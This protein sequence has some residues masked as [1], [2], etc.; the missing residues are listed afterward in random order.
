MLPGSDAVRNV[1]RGAVP[2]A[3]PADNH[4]FAAAPRK[5][6]DTADDDLARLARNKKQFKQFINKGG[7]ISICFDGHASSIFQRMSN[8]AMLAKE[9]SLTTAHSTISLAKISLHNGRFSCFSPKTP[10]AVFFR[11]AEIPDHPMVIAEH[12]LLA[13]NHL[14]NQSR[15]RIGGISCILLKA[16][17]KLTGI[18]FGSSSVILL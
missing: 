4:S 17:C 14:F 5:T 8:A 10:F 9:L 2:F 12:G 11:N 6:K 16:F 15:R 3:K 7:D 18:S 13:G 1:M